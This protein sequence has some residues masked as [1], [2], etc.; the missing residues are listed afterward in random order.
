MH[1]FK[2]VSASCLYYIFHKKLVYNALVTN[3][4]IHLQGWQKF[5]KKLSL[6]SKKLKHNAKSFLKSYCHSCCGGS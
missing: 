1:I 3:N 6:K 2:N 5:S 4:L